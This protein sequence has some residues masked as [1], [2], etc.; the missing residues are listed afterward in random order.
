MLTAVRRLSGIGAIVALSLAWS[1]PAFAQAGG[2]VYTLDQV[3]GAPHQIN[4]ESTP[5]PIG[6]HLDEV[7]GEFVWV[8]GLAFGGTHRLMFIRAAGGREERILIDVT[9]GAAPG[10]R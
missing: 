2:F 8:P 6:S 10:I 3:S 4:G 7:T 9:I 1:S 5:L